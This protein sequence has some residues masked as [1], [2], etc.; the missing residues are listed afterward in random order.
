[1]RNTRAQFAVSLTNVGCHWARLSW[2]PCAIRH[3]VFWCKSGAKQLSWIPLFG[4]DRQGYAGRFVLKH[5]GTRSII[6]HRQFLRW[7]VIKP[8]RNF[9]TSELPSF[10]SK[11]C[12]N[13][14]L[15]KSFSN[16]V[17]RTVISIIPDKGRANV[18]L[19]PI[20]PGLGHQVRKPD[21]CVGDLRCRNVGHT[22]GPATRI[23]MVT[24]GNGIKYQ[25][26]VASRE[27]SIER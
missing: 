7:L 9:F 25:R 10:R 19:P 6:P 1:M 18:L 27:D 4:F 23:A 3:V 20:T 26:I 16:V 11:R 13:E 21:G 22:T 14:S 17:C 2:C 15:C 24:D 5:G 12:E 8:D